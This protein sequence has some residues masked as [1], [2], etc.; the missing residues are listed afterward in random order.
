MIDVQSIA[1]RRRLLLLMEWGGGKGVARRK[2]I[3]V[4]TKDLPGGGGGESDVFLFSLSL[5]GLK[6]RFPFP[7]EQSSTCLQTWSARGR[8]GNSSEIPHTPV[9]GRD[10]GQRPRPTLFPP[11]PLSSLVVCRRQGGGGGKEQIYQTSSRVTYLENESLVEVR[12]ASLLLLPRLKTASFVGNQ[13]QP[14]RDE[15]TRS[16]FTPFS[17]K[18]H[19]KSNGH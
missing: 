2:R 9:I 1:S 12:V 11:H 16:I 15:T 18:R 17:V 7:L 19:S 3:F 4:K 5:S 14:G 6:L 10:V 13:V 8:P